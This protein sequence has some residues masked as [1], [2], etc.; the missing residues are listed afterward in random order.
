M[1]DLFYTIT[2]KIYWRIR[3]KISAKSRARVTVHKIAVFPL[4]AIKLSPQMF[5][6]VFHISKTSESTRDMDINFVWPQAS[7]DP[8]SVTQ[9]YCSLR[10]R[11]RAKNWTSS[12]LCDYLHISTRMSKL[13]ECMTAHYVAV[14]PLLE[15]IELSL[16]MF[17][18]K[19]AKILSVIIYNNK[20]PKISPGLICSTSVRVRH[21][22]GRYRCI[23]E[24]VGLK[25]SD[26]NLRFKC[27]WV[28][29]LLAM[30]LVFDN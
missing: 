27:A 30:L 28:H 8:L 22:R 4:E 25:V 3:C 26:G 10:D 20:I 9:H 11:E 2:L 12:S 18:N 13:R 1:V 6:C 7:S 5:H 29:I 15:A 14:S 17:T 16:Q 19:P 24:R 21:F 23:R